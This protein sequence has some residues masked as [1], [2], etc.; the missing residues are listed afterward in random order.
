MGF[1]DQHLGRSRG[2]LSTKIHALVDGLG[3]PTHLHLTAGNI[4]DATEGEKLVAAARGQT[5]IAD[6]AY[7]SNAIIAAAEAKGMTVVIPSKLNRKIQ[8]NID[9]S[10]YKERHLVENFFARLK[11]FSRVATR[12]EKT[13]LNFFGF[14]LVA[15]IRIWLA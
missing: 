15:S 1:Q 10:V 7:D 5:F 2:G 12:Y 9:L 6:K 14:V 11:Q 8:R 4:H 3:N 13:A